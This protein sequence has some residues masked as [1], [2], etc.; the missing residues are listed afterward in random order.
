MFPLISPDVLAD[1]RG[2]SMAACGVT[3]GLGAV[4][5]LLGWWAHRFW[6]VLLITLGAGLAGL[7]GGKSLGVPPPVAGLLLALAAGMLALSLARIATFIAT[8]LLTWLAIQHYLPAWDMPLVSFVLGGLVG[9]ILF[10][11]WLMAL[12]SLVGVLLAIHGGLL[13]AE[14]LGKVDAALWA[15]S[16]LQMLHMICAGGTLAGVFAQSIFDRWLWKRQQRAAAEAAPAPE[17]APAPAPAR[18]RRTWWQLFSTEG[19][20]RRA[21]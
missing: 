15:E 18:P 4:L 17:P 19:D 12:T 5:W 20:F 16:H 10:R 8:G 21:A 2:L 3:I 14:Q 7:S 6:I 11:F 9:L 1:L 13:L